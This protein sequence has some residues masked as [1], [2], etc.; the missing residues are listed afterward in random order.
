VCASASIAYVQRFC[1]YARLSS[2]SKLLR[3]ISRLP[4]F[5]NRAGSGYHR[6]RNH[7]IYSFTGSP[8]NL[9]SVNVKLAYEAV[10]RALRKNGH[11]QLVSIPSD[12][13]IFLELSVQERNGDVTGGS[14]F[15]TP[16]LQL[17]LV[18]R[19]T[20]A[21][22]WSIAEPIAN[23]R[24]SALAKNVDAA[25]NQLIADLDSLIHA[26]VPTDGLPK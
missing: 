6:T 26:Q 21:I 20:Q 16:G 2:S 17:R 10:Y 15:N 7:R 19:K 4:G 11:Y 23:G 1:S 25:A 3:S 18:D 12:A 13:E 5:R 24:K 8:V 9:G 14:S 22:L